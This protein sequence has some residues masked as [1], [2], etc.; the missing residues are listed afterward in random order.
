MSIK[1]EATREVLASELGQLKD[2]YSQMEQAFNEL[3]GLVS[4]PQIQGLGQVQEQQAQQQFQNIVLLE[5][6]R[7][8][9]QGQTS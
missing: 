5:Q 7:L 3:K 6:E 1:H 8:Q 9:N 4:R 2:K